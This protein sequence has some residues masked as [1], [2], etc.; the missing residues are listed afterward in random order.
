MR[1]TD[2]IDTQLAMAR[3]WRTPEAK[4]YGTY[5]LES[6]NRRNGREMYGR[7]YYERAMSAIGPWLGSSESYLIDRK[8]GQLL[9][10]AASTMPV[11]GVLPQDLPTPH[12]FLVLESPIHFLDIHGRR[13][14]VSGILWHS[15]TDDGVGGMNVLYFTDVYDMSDDYQA[16]LIETPGYTD[17]RMSLCH[18]EGFHWGQRPNMNTET[19]DVDWDEVRNLAI[20]AGDNM[21]EETIAR[22]KDPASF[23][24]YTRGSMLVW[25]F[26]TAFWTFSKQ[27]IV[28]PYRHAPDKWLR[29]RIERSKLGLTGDVNVVRLRAHEGRRSEPG[30]S[31]VEWSH[32]WIVRGHWHRY[33]V[34]DERGGK[35]LQ[36]RYLE[37]YRKGPD[38]KPLIIKD[39]VFVVNR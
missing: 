31:L 34:N 15:I 2:V 9:W 28:Q 12:G 36:A 38:D 13:M 4:T 22:Y 1:P 32:Q 7:E 26:L 29:K 25:Q 11:Q 24:E 18:A 23:A 37:P 17:Q 6:I 8:I 20:E 33:W 39:T 10:S 35:V 30:D 27:K 21:S 3:W 5:F 19:D 14:S 16:K